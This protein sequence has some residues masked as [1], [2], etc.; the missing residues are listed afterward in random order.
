MRALSNKGVL[1]Y[2]CDGVSP[3]SELPLTSPR[4]VDEPEAERKNETKGIR[5]LRR[6]AG[7]DARGQ[8]LPAPSLDSILEGL[9]GARYISKIDLKQAFLQVLMEESSKKYTA[10]AIDGSGLWQFKRMPFG[11]TGSP[12]TFCRPVNSL[13]GPKDQPQVFAYLDDILVVTETFDEHLKWLEYVLNKLVDVGL[14][15]NRDKCEFC[16]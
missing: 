10:F 16:C 13:F 12:A 8:R 7:A 9:C 6:A 5:I 14:K 15:V 2:I 1:C 3:T 11:L 4:M